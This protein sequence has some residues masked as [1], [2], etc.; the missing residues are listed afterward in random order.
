MELKDEKIVK[1]LEKIFMPLSVTGRAELAKCG[2]QFVHYTSAENALNILRSQKL[3]LRT[4]SCMNDYR[5]IS[6]GY[7]M[8][9]DFF[10]DDH[11]RKNFVTAI[12][13]YEDGLAKSIFEGF[14]EWWGKIRS[15]IFIA[16]ISV[17]HQNENQHGRLSM[18]R[19]YGSESGKA[20]L[21]LNNP[22]KSNTRLGVIL[23][24][25]AYFSPHDLK[26]ELYKVIDSINE[27]VEFLKGLERNTILSTVII[28]LI[29]LA[30]SLKHPGFEEEQEWRLIYLPKL[31]NNS[32]WVERSVESIGGVPQVVYKLPLKNS[33]KLEIEGLSP[34]DIISSIIIGPTQYP[35]AMFDAFID[36]LND[37][38]I[39]DASN[40]I[41]LSDIPL[42]T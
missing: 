40:K 15:N 41:V 13:S 7:Q 6:H 24:P 39:D 30:V 26:R 28:S 35:L 9:V 3:W 2:N 22:P 18:W 12:D 5:E 36:T 4:P 20:A 27:N 19:A 16:S 29:I 14:D 8:L 21:V 10:N 31:I 11:N 34:S 17:H 23:S 37:L 32:S 38:G 42:R 1:K 25:A 33:E